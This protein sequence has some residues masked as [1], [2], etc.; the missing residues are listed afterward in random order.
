MASEKPQFVAFRGIY[1]V[2]KQ[3]AI[4][5]KGMEMHCEKLVAFFSFA[6]VA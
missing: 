6:Q 3:R 1:A 2:T 4:P 5:N